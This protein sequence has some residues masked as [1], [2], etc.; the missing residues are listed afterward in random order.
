MKRAILIFAP[1]PTH[2]LSHTHTHTH[3][4]THP[5]FGNLEGLHDSFNTSF[6]VNTKCSIHSENFQ[7]LS[8]SMVPEMA[9]NKLV[10]VV[11]LV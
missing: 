11:S 10:I 6:Y 2:K 7:N 1:P 5:Y 3:T 4:H 8:A 9:L